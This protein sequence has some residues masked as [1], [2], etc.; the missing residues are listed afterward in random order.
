MN[1]DVEVL[2][3]QKGDV[4]IVNIK[5]D[6]TAITGKEIE[7]AY[8]KAS[9]EGE[10]KILFCFDK[11]GYINSGGIAIL[12]GIASESRKKEQIIRITGLSNHFQKIFRL[13]GLAL[14]TEI[15]PSEE[16]ALVDF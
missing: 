11:E 10:K 8:Q 13:V 4:S 12:I 1:K 14:Y 9:R 3:C 16:S 5:G 15:F 2:T 6:F 7:D